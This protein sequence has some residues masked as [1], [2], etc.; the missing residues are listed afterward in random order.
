MILNRMICAFV[1][2]NAEAEENS[3]FG[4]IP[5]RRRGLSMVP[6]DSSKNPNPAIRPNFHE[7]H[8]L[9]AE[10]KVASGLNPNYR[11]N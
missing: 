11:Y 1:L 2:P 4:R 3:P 9:G 10:P 8:Q 5:P 7:L 6:S